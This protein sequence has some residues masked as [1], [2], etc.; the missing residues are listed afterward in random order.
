MDY[1][2]M[3]T[4]H[5]SNAYYLRQQLRDVLE[6]SIV[7]LSCSRT[8]LQIDGSWTPNPTPHFSRINSTNSTN[9][10][11]LCSLTPSDSARLSA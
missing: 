10:Q 9:Q 7:W 4:T 5:V 8:T 3:P 6:T 11:V 1:H 2:R